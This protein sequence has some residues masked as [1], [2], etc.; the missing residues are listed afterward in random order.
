MKLNEFIATNFVVSMIFATVA[1]KMVITNY[2]FNYNRQ[3]CNFS[4]DMKNIGNGIFYTSRLETFVDI[5]AIKVPR[6]NYWNFPLLQIIYF[7]T[8]YI[9][10]QNGQ[11]TWKTAIMRNCWNKRST[12][13]TRKPLPTLYWKFILSKLRSLKGTL[14]IV[15]IKRL[16]YWLVHTILDFN[17][18]AVGS[19]NYKQYAWRLYG[20]SNF[21]EKCKSSVTPQ[22]SLEDG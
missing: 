9:F 21:E 14:N 2:L 6:S 5:P 13:A 10:L 15:L 8:R 4:I 3:Y 7:P 11:R 1:S 16:V 17:L 19:P 18:T 20:T 22:I 12:I